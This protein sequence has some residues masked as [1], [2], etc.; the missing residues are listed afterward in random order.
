MLQEGLNT[1]IE[2]TELLNNK[3]ITY[4]EKDERMKDLASILEDEQRRITELMIE[5]QSSEDRNNLRMNEK[6][7]AI[8]DLV[9]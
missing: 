6:Q 9:K 2:R 4:F 1:Q 7:E 8:A 3:L 5:Q